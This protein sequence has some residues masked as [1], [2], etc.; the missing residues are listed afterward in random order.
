MQPP[1]I[2]ALLLERQAL[3]GL[4]DQCVRHHG[5]LGECESET[6]QFIERCAYQIAER[7]SEIDA[8]VR[9]TIRQHDACVVEAALARPRRLGRAQSAMQCI[10]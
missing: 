10:G 1:D 8:Q 9:F 7:W 6:A 4:A 3:R 2:K 5:E